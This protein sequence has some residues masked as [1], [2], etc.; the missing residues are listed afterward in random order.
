MRLVI[1]EDDLLL[2]LC[3]RE[4]VEEAGHYVV[5]CEPSAARVL[6]RAQEDGADLALVNISLNEGST[7]GLKLAEDL[8]VQLAIPSIFV[9][10][11][12]QDAMTAK[13]VALGYLP[14]PYTP[15][16]LVASISVAE[17]LSQGGSPPPPAI[18]TCLELF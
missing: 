7:A 5:C 14:K 10:G 9:S 11:Q 6:Q 2:A 4:A 12:R 13:R 16:D 18:P 15:D 8:K 1:A 3:V 17:V